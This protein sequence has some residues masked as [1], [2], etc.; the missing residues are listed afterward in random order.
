MPIKI[1]PPHA[2]N[3]NNENLFQLIRNMLT[4]HIFFYIFGY[5]ETISWRLVIFRAD[6]PT[7][8]I[9]KVLI[10][11]LLSK[12]SMFF[13]LEKSSPQNIA[14]FRVNEFSSDI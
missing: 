4:I 12:F 13:F 8:A 1:P 2:G 9:I 6:L 3:P 10:A 5:E 14:Q 11:I 7:F